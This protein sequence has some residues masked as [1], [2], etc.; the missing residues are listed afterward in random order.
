MGLD[1]YIYADT[2]NGAPST[3]RGREIDQFQRMSKETML[4]SDKISES[5]KEELRA[6]PPISAYWRKHA[7]LHN[8]IVARHAGGE[9]NCEPIPLTEARC[10]DIAAWLQDGKISTDPDFNQGFFFGGEDLWKDALKARHEDAIYFEELGKWI[11]QNSQSK[12]YYQ[13]SW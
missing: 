12:C 9:D 8:Y 3:E 11:A 5:L 2:D 6:E 10:N 1:M 13:A 4:E 7:P